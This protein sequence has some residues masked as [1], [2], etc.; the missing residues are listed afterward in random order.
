M[1][2]YGMDKWRYSSTYSLCRYYMEVI[3]SLTVRPS[4][5]DPLYRR[6]S[7]PQSRSGRCTE[8][9]HA[10]N[11]TQIPRFWPCPLANLCI[12][13]YLPATK[14]LIIQNK[15]YS[16]ECDLVL[17]A[18]RSGVGFMGIS[19]TQSTALQYVCVRDWIHGMN[20][21]RTQYMLHM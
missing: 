18:S 5:R 2:T 9:C 21:S 6:L 20:P 15:R 11:R 8:I 14:Y 12:H 7:G 3:L 13:W 17:N 19:F 1:K 10:G 16:R 4:R